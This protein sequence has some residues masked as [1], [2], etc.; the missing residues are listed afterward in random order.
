[1]SLLQTAPGFGVPRIVNLNADKFCSFIWKQLLVLPYLFLCPISDKFNL[2]VLVILIQILET[3]FLI[4][5]T[6]CQIPLSFKMHFWIIFS[7]RP[8]HLHPLLRWQHM[9]LSSGLGVC[10]TW[11]L[12]WIQ[13][14]CC[15][16]GDLILIGT[17]G[18]IRLLHQILYRLWHY[19]NIVWI[20]N[21]AATVQWSS[22]RSLS[23]CL[24]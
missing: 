18:L 19:W 23:M 17:A 1:M 11:K 16:S 7:N 8:A 3:F 14:V 4:Q 24:F 5:E 20:V 2:S 13:A 10:F 21:W 9:F 15:L 6:A 22:D 12:N